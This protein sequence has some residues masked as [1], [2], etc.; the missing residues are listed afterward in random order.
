MNSETMINLHALLI[1]YLTIEC[2][3][4]LFLNNGIL[5]N[6]IFKDIFN[7]K[8]SSTG[9]YHQREN[10]EVDTI[11]EHTFE[12]LYAATKIFSLFGIDKENGIIE[13][14]SSLNT[15][16]LAIYLHDIL[17]YGENNENTH[18][19]KN[20]DEIAGIFI[21][22]NKSIFEKHTNFQK[23]YDAV[24]FHSGRWSTNFD[25]KLFTNM[26]FFTHVLDMLSTYNCLKIEKINI[27]E[28]F[29]NN[30]DKLSLFLQCTQNME[31]N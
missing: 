23:L 16:I 6:K 3:S 5:T 24:R 12:M 28:L 2:Y 4:E 13:N 11:G 31:Q 7:K 14:S 10:G 15:I 27:D 21:F 25:N 26:P 17:K 9:K 29:K 8:S 18:T 1:R 22:Q 30:D 20:H 19:A